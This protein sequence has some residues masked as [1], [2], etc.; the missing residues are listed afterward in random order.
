LSWHR[1]LT[2]AGR[3]PSLDKLHI[4]GV[5]VVL[6]DYFFGMRA[7]NHVFSTVDEWTRRRATESVAAKLFVWTHGGAENGALLV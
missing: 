6:V 4:D 3:Q 2:E 1:R 5:D 7:E